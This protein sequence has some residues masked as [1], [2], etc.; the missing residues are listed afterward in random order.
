MRAARSRLPP[1]E[2]V[3][4]LGD[5]YPSAHA[6]SAAV[7]IASQRLRFQL[8]RKLGLPLSVADT[9]LAAAAATA[10]AW[11]QEQISDTLTRSAAAGKSE[12]LSDRDTL[13]LVQKIL[14]Y[15]EKL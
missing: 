9:E 3:E 6:G 8:T 14:H 5:L 12:I 1:L 7:R 4:T 10:F 11:N 13:E 2:F 15:S